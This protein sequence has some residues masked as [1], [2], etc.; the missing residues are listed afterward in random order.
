MTIKLNNETYETKPLDCWA[1]VKELRSK[2]FWHTWNAQKQGGLLFLGQVYMYHGFYRGWGHYANPS[3][4]AHFTR[5]ARTPNAEGLTQVI[6]AAEAMGLGRDVC[7]A[8][9]DHVGQVFAGLSQTSPTG[10]KFKHDMAVAG[11]SCHAIRKT[12][13]IAAEFMGV[14]VYYIDHKVGR[15]SEKTHRMEPDE[16]AKA[17][18]MAQMNEGIEWA[19]KKLGRKYDDEA[20]IEGLKAEWHSRITW[21]KCVEVMQNIPSPISSRTAMSVRLP[22]VTNTADPE[23]AKYTDILYDELKYRASKKISDHKYEK[24]RINHEGVHPLYRADVLRSP[25]LYGAVFVTGALTE[26]YALYDRDENRHSRVPKNPL[27]SGTVLRTRDDILES[28][29]QMVILRTNT[30]DQP[31][32]R[33]INWY[34]RAVDW[35]ASAI[36]GHNDRPCQPVMCVAFEAGTYCR[37]RGIP[38][39]NYTSSQGDPRDFDERRILGPGGELPTFYESLGLTRLD[40]TVHPRLHVEVSDD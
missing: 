17:Y 39:G 5:L 23:V 40:S 22:L 24:L 27:E 8:M 13:Q 34:A 36:V 15:Y 29:W 28:V 38:V 21:A 11:A 9:K 25:E 32:N 14:P 3:I 19:E 6:E 30:V 2:H 31:Q 33:P 26:N 7:G 12:T 1:K 4:G 18:W 35:K 16:N 10:E 37:E 20:A